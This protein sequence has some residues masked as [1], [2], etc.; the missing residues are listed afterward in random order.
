MDTSERGRVNRESEGGQIWSMY[1]VYMYENKTIKPAEI[2]LR[3][4]EEERGRVMEG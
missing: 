1:W 4:E 2:V 3:S